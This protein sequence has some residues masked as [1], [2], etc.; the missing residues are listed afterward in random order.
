MLRALS[1]PLGEIAPL[2]EP[3][4]RLIVVGSAPP[5]EGPFE[6]LEGV[7]AELGSVHVFRRRPGGVSRETP[8]PA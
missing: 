6:R 1:L 4:G 2:L 8:G 7:G 3:G 5:V